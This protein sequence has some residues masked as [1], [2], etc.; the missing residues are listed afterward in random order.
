MSAIAG[1]LTVTVTDAVD[2]WLTPSN[3][4]VTVSVNVVGVSM[5]ERC[6]VRVEPAPPPEVGVTEVGLKLTDAP[7]GAPEALSATAEL[8]PLTESTVTEVEAVP[9]T[10]TVTGLIRPIEKSTTAT[11]NVPVLEFPAGSVAVQVTVVAPAGNV[12][13]G[14]GLQLTVRVEVA[15]SGSVAETANVTTAPLALV[16][17]AVLPAA[18]VAE[19]VMVVLPS[20]KVL[21]EAGAHVGVSEPDTASVAVAV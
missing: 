1:L 7:A 19:Q 6:R 4:P 16:A 13:P 15:L 9:P 20:G 10:E 14:G 3:V 5:G 11:W 17:V 12:E 8:K 21:P 2:V 18:S